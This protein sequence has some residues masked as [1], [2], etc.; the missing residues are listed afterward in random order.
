MDLAL[1]NLIRTFVGKSSIVDWVGVLI[2]QYLP[3][4]MGIAALVFLLKI[5]PW[6][7]RAEAL[8]VAALALLLSRGLLTELIRFFYHARLRP[9]VALGFTP[10]IMESSAS[11]PSGHAAFFFALSAVVFSMNRTW[12]WWFFALS[13]LNGIARVYVGVHWPSDIVGGAIIGIL[14]FFVVDYLMK[15]AKRPKIK[16]ASL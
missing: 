1:F 9:F 13:L 5:T 10:L 8:L 4:V 14:S 12:G 6:K 3:Y 15:R 7:A 2:A 11:F 16:P